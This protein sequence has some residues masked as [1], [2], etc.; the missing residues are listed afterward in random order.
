MEDAGIREELARC[1]RR[2]VEAGLLAGAGG[3]ISARA[4]TLVYVSPSGKGLDELD[5]GDYIAVELA[6]GTAAAG[7]AKPT[8]E[9]DMH[10]G[11]YRERDDVTAV[12]HTHPPWVTGVASAGIE[13]RAMLPEI[14]YC[15]GPLAHVG[16]AAPGSE[17]LA[18]EVCEAMREA[19]SVLMSN[20]GVLA[21][22]ATLKEAFDR[23]VLLESAA[24]TLVAASIV[25]KPRFLT[26]EE[27][28]EIDAPTVGGQGKR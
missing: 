25:G 18:R 10:L 28:E 7:S 27:M 24:K 4:G 13:M 9:L 26:P 11:C 6:T 23:N 5:P 3:N 20:H 2:L 21:V 15:V 12:V 14:A 19:N 1:G 22:G 16:Y 8:K 17:K